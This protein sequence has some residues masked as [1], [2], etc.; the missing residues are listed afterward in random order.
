MSIFLKCSLGLCSSGMKKKVRW[1]V[2]NTLIWWLEINDLQ[3][4]SMSSIMKFP[5]ENNPNLVGLCNILSVRFY[6]S[7]RSNFSTE[8]ERRRDY[9]WVWH[10]TLLT[11]KW[12][13][14]DGSI[15][16]ITSD[17]QTGQW[18]VIPMDEKTDIW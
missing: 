8:I 10:S 3:K 13:N 5:G 6:F 12:P 4:C 9:Q 1:E 2:G 17:W 7:A 15:F 14:I 18:T 16:N 11:E